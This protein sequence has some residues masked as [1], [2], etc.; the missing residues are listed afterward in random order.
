MNVYSTITLLNCPQN[1]GM[2]QFEHTSRRVSLNVSWR[3][4]L[5]L[6]ITSN[7]ATLKEANIL[8]AKYCVYV[9]FQFQLNNSPKCCWSCVPRLS[10]KWVAKIGGPN[11]FASRIKRVVRTYAPIKTYGT[12]QYILRSWSH[13]NRISDDL[14][15]EL[16][17]RKRRKNAQIV[18]YHIYLNLWRS[19]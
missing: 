3:C 11:Q 19:L 7:K 15:S 2:L 12:T 6:S 1:K 4:R 17:T 10:A 5:N 9:N 8:N 16:A 13:F 18:A 14:N